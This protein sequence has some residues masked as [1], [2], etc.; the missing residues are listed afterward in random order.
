MRGLTQADDMQTSLD[1]KCAEEF[2]NAEYENPI[3]PFENLRE[4][5]FHTFQHLYDV[6][7]NSANGW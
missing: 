1:M 2:H 6:A 5:Y 7:V 3:K 4:T